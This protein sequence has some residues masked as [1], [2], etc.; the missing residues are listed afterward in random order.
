MVLDKPLDNVNADSSLLPGFAGSL[1][2]QTVGDE[3]LRSG[4]KSWQK[5]RPSIEILC[6]NQASYVF[7]SIYSNGHIYNLVFW[8]P[9][10]S[11]FTLYFFIVDLLFDYVCVCLLESVHFSY[12]HFWSPMVLFLASN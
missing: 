8:L 6:N 1:Q 7:L 4:F 2:L 5:V 12:C 11:K 10:W 9:R 3:P